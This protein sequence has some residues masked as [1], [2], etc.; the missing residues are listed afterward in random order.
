MKTMHEKFEEL[1]SILKLS[2]DVQYDGNNIAIIAADNPDKNI[3]LEL[4]NNI[5]TV[6]IEDE[7]DQVLY[8]S[9]ETSVGVRVLDI[10]NILI[11]HA[12]LHHGPLALSTYL[13]C[14]LLGILWGIKAEHRMK[15]QNPVP[16][17]TM[18]I[19]LYGKKDQNVTVFDY[20]A[21]KDGT[22]RILKHID[23]VNTEIYSFHPIEYIQDAEK[24]VT[25][26]LNF[27][28]DIEYISSAEKG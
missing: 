7:V 18:F 20:M 1:L 4:N 19:R 16:Q 2:Y 15:D 14:T 26:F 6:Y 5:I 3:K 17:D 10:E 21:C 8:L 28:G 25:E 12:K 13:Y 22:I 27:F 9:D 23:P 24:I 11:R